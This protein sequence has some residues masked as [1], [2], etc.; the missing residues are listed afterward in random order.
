MTE[1]NFPKLDFSWIADLPSKWDEAA[2]LNQQKQALGGLD[3]S[4]PNSLDKAATLLARDPRGLGLAEQLATAAQKR[5][6]LQQQE[7]L[8]GLFGKTLGGP[9][10]GPGAPTGARPPP[11]MGGAP[12]GAPGPLSDNWGRWLAGTS[13]LESD[14]NPSARNPNSSAT[15]AF[16]FTKATAEDAI[17]AGLPDPRVGNYA[18]QADATRQF[19]QKFHPDA[20]AAIE[21]G[22]YA[23]ADRILNKRWS[24]LPGGVEMQGP[25]RYAT[26]NSILG[27]AA[28]GGP[29]TIQAPQA[30]GPP[31]VQVAGPGAP[32]AA[33]TG[34]PATVATAPTGAP[35]AAPEGPPQEGQFDLGAAVKRAAGVQPSVAPTFQPQPASPRVIRLQQIA[36]AMTGPGAVT[37]REQAAAEAKYERDM[38]TAQHGASL[39]QWEAQTKV[40]YEDL[41]KYKTE[42]FNTAADARKQMGT[43]NAMDALMQSPGFMSG[44]GADLAVRYGG[45]IAGI[46]Q[47]A[48]QAADIA[49][50]PGLG[51]YADKLLNAVQSRTGV[52]EAFNALHAQLTLQSLGGSLGR[53]ISDQDRNFI[54]GMI[55]SLGAT[56]AAN[57]FIRDY[58][59]AQNKRSEEVAKITKAYR[60]SDRAGL[61]E[62]LSQYAQANP[63]WMKA[64]GTPTEAGKK[65][66]EKTQKGAVGTSAGGLTGMDLIR[67][68]MGVRTSEEQ[69][70]GAPLPGVPN[71]TIPAS[72][73]PAQS[74]PAPAAGGGR[75][76]IDENGNVWMVYPGGRKEMIQPGAGGT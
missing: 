23:A 49:G 16:Q 20:A 53:Q 38:Q 64:D 30:P 50:L 22:D 74:A 27:G 3:F 11:P 46:A 21:K 34:A 47:A 12:V 7:A 41:A 58:M 62:I 75:R 51:A 2:L 60:G 40:D 43:I 39:K 54:S 44:S 1:L 5:R 56:P 25:G 28:G 33:P 55:M 45:R 24:S 17:R 59:T 67:R 8:Q 35:A 15:G 66:L 4:D 70:T 52:M 9:A 36:N 68:F 73:A 72:A 61:E 76:A 18:Q 37:A 10:E 19:I 57:Q 65:A 26:R 29:A 31:P 48:K 42:V 13:Y 32:P 14:F 6:E 69:A 71:P 63:L